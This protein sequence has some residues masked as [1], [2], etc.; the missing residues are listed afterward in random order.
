MKPSFHFLF[1]ILAFFR[2]KDKPNVLLVSI[3][4]I[5]VIPSTA[6]S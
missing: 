5:H 4:D 2:A 6:K 1:L 3:D